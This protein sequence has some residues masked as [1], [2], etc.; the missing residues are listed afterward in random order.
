MKESIKKFLVIAA[1][2]AGILL[3]ISIDG[4]LGE[5]GC[6]EG[7]YNQTTGECIAR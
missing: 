3:L 2:V 7:Q 1:L 5:E 6:G 4:K